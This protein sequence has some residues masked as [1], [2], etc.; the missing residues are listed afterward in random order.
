MRTNCNRRPTVRCRDIQHESGHQSSCLAPEV[1]IRSL[2]NLVPKLR[3]LR[4][5]FA[6]DIYLI[7]KAVYFVANVR[8]TV[9]K[10]VGRQG[11]DRRLPLIEAGFSEDSTSSM[12]WAAHGLD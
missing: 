9:L 11:F 4:L 10:R 8:Q 2:Q 6:T 7:F 12:F 5:S 3:F 1:D